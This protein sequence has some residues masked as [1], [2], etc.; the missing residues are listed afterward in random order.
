MQMR[1][2]GTSQPL[3][4]VWLKSGTGQV[5]AH[6]SPR[7]F[8]WKSRGLGWLLRR[9]FPPDAGS[10]NIPSRC[11]F[12]PPLRKWRT[13]QTHSR[14]C[15]FCPLCQHSPPAASCRAAGRLHRL[16]PRRPPPNRL[17]PA[18]PV[19]V[20]RG[21]SRPREECVRGGRARPRL[22]A[23]AAGGAAGGGGRWRN[24]SSDML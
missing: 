7:L 15:L 5:G 13:E 8:G 10:Q 21:G 24:G 4:Y 14:P 22:L 16:L 3:P 12:T 19:L 9:I 18:P 2:G 20:A 6:P 17:R 23:P 1:G 11:G